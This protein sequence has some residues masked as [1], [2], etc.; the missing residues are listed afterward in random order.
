MREHKAKDARVYRVFYSGYHKGTG[1]DCVVF[2]DRLEVETNA[3]PLVLE[4]WEPFEFFSVKDGGSYKI[5]E[6]SCGLRLVT[7]GNACTRLSDA[8]AKVLRQLACTFGSEK[9]PHTV[10][11]DAIRKVI[12]A[13]EEAGLRT[14]Q[15]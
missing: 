13:Q 8:I 9:E 14:Q 6:A 4:G 1:K 11:R 15:A 12:M 5:Y 3:R 10:L 2:P 7:S